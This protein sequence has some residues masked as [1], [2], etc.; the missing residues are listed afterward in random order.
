MINQESG[1]AFRSHRI[2]CANYPVAK[3]LQKV[4]IHKYFMYG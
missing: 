2:F 1:V 4:L 3:K